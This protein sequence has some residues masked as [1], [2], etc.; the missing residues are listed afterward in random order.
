MGYTLTRLGVENAS[1]GATAPSFGEKG[2]RASAISSGNADIANTVDAANAANAA[3]AAAARAAD[4]HR[5]RA[6]FDY[7]RKM[8]R[9]GKVR[10][11]G[12]FESLSMWLKGLA[13]G[14]AGLPRLAQSGRWESP[15]LLRE[16]RAYNEACDRVWGALQLDLKKRYALVPTL[17]SHARR[18]EEGIGRL[19]M[20]LDAMKPGEEYFTAKKCGEAVDIRIFVRIICA[21]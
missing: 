1:A 10:H 7:Q 17:V 2:V 12:A 13:D 3:V 15:K 20:Q 21:V 4:G 19:T 8:L 6:A 5:S 14:R 9:N 11:I 16:A 18:C